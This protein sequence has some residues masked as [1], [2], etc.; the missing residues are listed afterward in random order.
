MKPPFFCWTLC[1]VASQNFSGPHLRLPTSISLLL[2][3][4]SSQ[5]WTKHCDHTDLFWRP[6]IFC[7]HKGPQK[8]LCHENVG[9][10]LWPQIPTPLPDND[11]PWNCLVQMVRLRFFCRPKASSLGRMRLHYGYT[12]SNRE[13]YH[14][15]NMI[16]QKH[17]GKHRKYSIII[18]GNCGW[19]QGQ[20]WWKLTTTCFPGCYFPIQV[21]SAWADK[22]HRTMSK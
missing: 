1:L 18:W 7:T 10:I 14:G 17:P 11:P 15:K 5:H 4:H 16:Q 3:S 19:F 2:G 12:S 20:S 8:G 21:A 13:S 6:E 22:R 9:G